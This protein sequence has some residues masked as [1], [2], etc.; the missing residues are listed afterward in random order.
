M[1]LETDVGG[2][3]VGAGVTDATV[4]CKVSRFTVVTSLVLSDWTEICKEKVGV[5]VGVLTTAGE[6]GVETI[7]DIGG[8]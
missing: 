5:M 3:K 2:G 7:S 4:G 6:G 1:A 8:D